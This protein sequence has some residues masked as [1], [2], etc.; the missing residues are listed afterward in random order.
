MSETRRKW[1]YQILENKRI[2]TAANIINISLMVLILLNVISIV[3]ASEPS[4]REKYAMY[5]HRLDVFTL[6]VFTVEYLI[7]VWISIERK[8]KEEHHPILTR[9]RYMATPMALVDLLAI[10]PSYLLF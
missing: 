5:F 1:L 10:L 6:V 2:G 7:R 3:A 8:A 4:I 9:L